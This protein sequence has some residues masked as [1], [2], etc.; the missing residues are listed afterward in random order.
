MTQVLST[1]YGFQNYESPE[2]FTSYYYQVHAVLEL[3]PQSLLEVGIGSGILAAFL[4]KQGIEALSVDLDPALRPSIGGSVLQL[5]L[6]SDS[7][8]VTAAFQVLEHLP[9]SNFANA[10]AELAR[11]ARKG[12][13]L[14]LPEFGN[15]AITISIPFVRKLRFAWRALGIW[16]P[17]HH[18]D[19]E[20]YWEINKRGYRLREVVQIMT[21]HQLAL[22]DTW[23]NPYNPYHRFFVL[24]KDQ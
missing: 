9:Y 5:P 4:R 19:G 1:H 20:H 6:Q 16:H 14:S 8:D 2:R 23:R 10:V 17:R 21:D 13:V 18:F 22:V 24:R 7:I 3:A 11:V 12:V 15:A